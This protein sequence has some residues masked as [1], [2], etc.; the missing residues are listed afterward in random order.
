M[1]FQSFN[2]NLV[3][4]VV[5]R[6]G[7]PLRSS[8]GNPVATSITRGYASGSNN[9]NTPLKFWP[10]LVILA[11]GSGTYALMLKTR[12]SNPDFRKGKGPKLTPD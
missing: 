6:G 10:F 4:R 2:L 12:A 8:T 3:T 1:P 11:A 7:P 9:N 5:Q